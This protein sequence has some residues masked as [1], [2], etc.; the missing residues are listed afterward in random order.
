MGIIDKRVAVRRVNKDPTGQSHE[1]RSARET[2]G[3]VS[4]PM[5]SRK[6]IPVLI[7]DDDRAVFFNRDD[8]G[9]LDQGSIVA[10]QYGMS[11]E[12]E[13]QKNECHVQLLLPSYVRRQRPRITLRL[14]SHK[15]PCPSRPGST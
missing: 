4:E 13:E 14:T 6:D 2:D 3:E 12:L 9:F 10:F 15:T 1:I 5:H 11:V 7:R 8:A